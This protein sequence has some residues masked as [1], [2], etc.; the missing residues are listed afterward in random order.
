MYYI[1]NKTLACPL[2]ETK[3]RKSISSL[4]LTCDDIQSVSSE[5][6]KN[7]K[8]PVLL[9][10]MIFSFGFRNDNL[11]MHSSV[12]AQLILKISK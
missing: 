11:C 3:D 8:K 10:K 12:F 4:V 2:N 5:K 6:N 1:S 7:K 9:L